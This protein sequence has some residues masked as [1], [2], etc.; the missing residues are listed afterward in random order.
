[1]EESLRYGIFYV[2][3]SPTVGSTVQ[4]VE[5]MAFTKG[6]APAEKRDGDGRS[7]ESI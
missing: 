5:S 4:E 1:M 6:M 3:I 7:V 2:C